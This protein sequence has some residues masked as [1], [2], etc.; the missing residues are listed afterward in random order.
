MFAA[1]AAAAAAAAPLGG[2]WRSFGTVWGSFVDPNGPKSDK[3]QLFAVTFFGTRFGSMFSCIFA[4]SR[5]ILVDSGLCG[6]PFGYVKHRSKC[7]FA[8]SDIFAIS[9][10][11]CSIFGRFWL[12]L[13][14]FGDPNHQKSRRKGSQNRGR[15]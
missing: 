2:I 7:T 6:E 1:A 14:S 8:F 4:P 11:F 15:K 3:K 9:G 5:P 13:T 10:E 12:I